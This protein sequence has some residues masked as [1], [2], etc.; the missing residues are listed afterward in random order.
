MSYLVEDTFY[1]KHT[2]RLNTIQY[3][4]HPDLS[5]QV[6]FQKDTISVECLTGQN[7][8]LLLY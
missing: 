5:H 2:D 1:N 8:S 4:S 7:I 6:L 3:P